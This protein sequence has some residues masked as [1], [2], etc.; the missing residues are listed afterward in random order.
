MKY[1]ITEYSDNELSLIV[2]NDESLYC[3]RRR[4]LLDIELCKN[5][6][7]DEYFIYTE[8]QKEQLRI[9]L[10]EDLNNE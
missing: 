2:F 10:E 9:D 8:E 6:L 3:M 5:S 7:L 1:N 4:L